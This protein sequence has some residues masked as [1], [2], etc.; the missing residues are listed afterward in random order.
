MDRYV[1]IGLFIGFFIVGPLIGWLAGLANPTGWMG[2]L[3]WQ[4]PKCT[5]PDDWAWTYRHHEQCGRAHPP[6]R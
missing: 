1:V 6:R 5:C 2:V 4:V 3:P